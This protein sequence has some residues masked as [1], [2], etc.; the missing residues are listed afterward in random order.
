MTGQGGHDDDV[1]RPMKP[2]TICSD[3]HLPFA[4]SV[5]MRH[6]SFCRCIDIHL[7]DIVGPHGQRRAL[8][9]LARCV[10]P[11]LRQQAHRARAVPCE[12]WS[13]AAVRNERSCILAPTLQL[14]CAAAHPLTRDCNRHRSRCC[15][16][17]HHRAFDMQPPPPSHPGL[18]V[19]SAPPA[20]LNPRP[21]THVCPLVP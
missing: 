4:P 8:G 16:H 12:R 1:P 20:P 5:R 17:N 7:P 19:D 3:P 14:S 13:H 15:H 10:A 18:M 6:A 9:A 2:V 11:G 21:M